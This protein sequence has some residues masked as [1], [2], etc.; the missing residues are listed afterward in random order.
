M[1]HSTALGRQP[2]PKHEWVR[3]IAT[4]LCGVLSST[5]PGPPFFLFSFFNSLDTEQRS[6][7]GAADVA[8]VF[9]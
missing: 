2:I 7:S 5:A 4:S 1:I 6:A 8:S 9:H 3:E